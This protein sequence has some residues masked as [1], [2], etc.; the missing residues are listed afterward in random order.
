MRLW[1]NETEQCLE[2]Y[3]AWLGCKWWRDA[4]DGANAPAL[5]L[6]RVPHLVHIRHTPPGTSNHGQKSKSCDLCKT[7]RLKFE[8][9]ITY[10]LPPWKERQEERE[11]EEIKRCGMEGK[12]GL[13][14]ESGRGFL[15]RVLVSWCGS[16]QISL[17]ILEESF[18][19]ALEHGSEQ[20][21]EGL[22]GKHQQNLE[23]P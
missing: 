6:V 11:R 21:Q 14:G 10:P 19:I 7:R 13:Q 8:K 20:K 2:W 5:L 18:L 1:R 16:S 4:F 22:W 3:M 12:E 9:L 17:G 23:E 15:R